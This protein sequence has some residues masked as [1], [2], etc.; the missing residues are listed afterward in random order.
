MSGCHPTQVRDGNVDLLPLQSGDLA[1]Q[2]DVVGVLVDEDL[3]D[4]AIGVLRARERERR[5]WLHHDT[6]RW[7]LRTGSLLADDHQHFVLGRNA[8]EALGA[9]FADLHQ[10][11]ALR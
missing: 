6:L 3:G 4:E 10:D 1:S 8:L 5:R 9:V 2:R 11:H 7:A